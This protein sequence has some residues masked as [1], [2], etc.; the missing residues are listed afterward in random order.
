MAKSNRIATNRNNTE[1]WVKMASLLVQIDGTGGVQG[2]PFCVWGPPAAA[3]SAKLKAIGRVLGK[4]VKVFLGSSAE[5]TD[6]AIPVPDLERGTVRRLVQS[7]AKDLKEEGG[8]LFLD[9]ASSSPPA[10]QAALMSVTHDRMM[11]DEDISNVAVV[12]AANPVDIAAGGNEIALPMLNRMLHM[13]V[14][15]PPAK[16]VG[17]YLSGEFA[18]NDTD[19]QLKVPVLDPDRYKRELFRVGVIQQAF[20]SR[21]SGVFEVDLKGIVPSIEPAFPSPRSWELGMRAFAAGVAVDDVELATEMLACAVGDGVAG[22]FSAFRTAVDLP[23]T[24]ALLDGR[25]KWTPDPARAD[26][27]MTVLL[28]VAAEAIRRMK[29]TDIERAWD[30]LTVVGDAKDLAI[31]A[32]E[33][34]T[35]IRTAQFKGKKVPKMGPVEA[36]VKI[37]IGQYMVRE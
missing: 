31:P 6:L 20:L 8:I 4:K 11:G 37:A 32:A 23:D 1:N 9:E 13:F 5:P 34:L 16:E 21:K 3:K 24:E 19:S 18:G 27:T 14:Q 28:G 22:E 35:T 7:W 30:L 17:Q 10:M 26:R 15:T 33:N 36:R 12:M 29:E 2:V 25:I